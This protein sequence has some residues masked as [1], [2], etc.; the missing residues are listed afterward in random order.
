MQGSSESTP[1][2]TVPCGSNATE[3]RQP[4][5]PHEAKPPPPHE[6][7]TPETIQAAPIG[8]LKHRNYLCPAL[9]PERVR[10]APPGMRYKARLNTHSDLAMERALMPAISHIVPPT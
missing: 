6:A 9:E 1:A 5:G 7:A 3:A 10:H 2:T 4:T 8:T